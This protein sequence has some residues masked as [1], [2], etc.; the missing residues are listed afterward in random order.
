[1]KSEFRIANSELRNRRRLPFLNS[2]FAIRYSKFVLLLLFAFPLLAQEEPARID[3]RPILLFNQHLYYGTFSKPRAIAYDRQHGELWVADSGNNM[4]GIYR[5]DGAELFSFSSKEYLRSPSRIAI[6]PSGSAAVIEG[7]R[8]HVR[9]FNYRGEYKGDLNLPELGKKPV[10]GAIAY[11]GDGNV[12]VG[13]NASAQIFVYSADGKLRR[14]FGSRGTDDGQ[15]RAIIAMT[16][17]SDGRIYVLD[18]QSTAVQ[19][20][21]HQGN[22]ERGWGRHEMGAENVSL[23]S[24]IAVDSKGRVIICDEL[25]HQ[26]KVFTGDGKLIA[27]FGGLGRDLGTTSFPTD[28][29][30]DEHDRIYV[31]ERGTSRVQV[32]EPVK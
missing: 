5:P 8:A 10:L 32:F 4:I 24:G 26:I 16:V 14:Q 23:P 29:T 25:R 22:F 18:A 11:D 3:Y 6:A 21:D 1:M 12:Y 30:V 19:V 27:I 31:T 2:E 7:D 20:F 15:F 28:L 13:D 17:G 9:T